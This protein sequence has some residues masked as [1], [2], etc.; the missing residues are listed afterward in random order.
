MRTSTVAQQAV[1]IARRVVEEKNLTLSTGSRSNLQR[2]IVMFLNQGH[3][4]KNTYKI[5]M[6]L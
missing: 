1:V 6:S 5:A 3:S 2:L 4:E